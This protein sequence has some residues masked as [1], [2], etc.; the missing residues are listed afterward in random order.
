MRLED[1]KDKVVIITGAGGGIGQALAKGYAEQGSKVVLAD[2]SVEKALEAKEIIDQCGGTSFAIKCDVTNEKDVMNMVGEV[3]N[4]FNTI[5]I[6][7]NN[8]GVE[9]GTK[10][11]TELRED[12]WDLILNV[13]LKGPFLCSKHVGKLFCEKREGVIINIASL[14]AKIPRWYLGAYSTSKAAVVQL[15]KVMALEMA[16]YNVRVN[17]VCPGATNTPMFEET[18]KSNPNFSLDHFLL[19]NPKTFRAGIPLRRVADPEDQV[20]AALYL[21]SSAANHIT[22]QLIF[23]DGGESV[24]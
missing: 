18:Q 11:L 16:E 7:V 8:A 4:Q 3:I 23:V 10:P 19:G 17:A 15:T 5:D 12:E 22:G 2:V 9:T 1:L 20:N 24:I 13:N 6:L 14:T 21:S